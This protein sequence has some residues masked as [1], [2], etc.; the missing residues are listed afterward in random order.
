MST[1]RE[2]LEK[3]TLYQLGRY[4]L[5]G[6]VAAV[7]EFGSYLLLLE[8]GLWYV[9][10]GAASGVFGFAAAFLGHKYVVFRKPK[11]FTRHLIRFAVLDLFNT[12]SATALLFVL[13]EIAEL[14][15]D[16]SKFISM[17]AV[18]LWNFALYKRLVYV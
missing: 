15:E 17:A 14:R 7:V 2:L 11:A 5:S 16:L 12:I 6:G 9:H 10:A 4:L 18:V 13:V 8:L 1:L 3:Q